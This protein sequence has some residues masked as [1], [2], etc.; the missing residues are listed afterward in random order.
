MRLVLH[1]CRLLL[2]RGRILYSVDLLLHD[3]DVL[4]TVV[5]PLNVAHVI[6]RGQLTSCSF[7]LQVLHRCVQLGWKGLVMNALLVVCLLYRLLKFELLC[8]LEFLK[9]DLVSELVQMI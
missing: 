7:F 9:L 4:R 3:A 2:C 5:V 1:V 8:F 6:E